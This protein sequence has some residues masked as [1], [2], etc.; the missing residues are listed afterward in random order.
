[1]VHSQSG[2]AHMVEIR[3]IEFACLSICFLLII[4]HDYILLVHFKNVT[5]LQKLAGF[6]SV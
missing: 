2:N 3:V 1:M 6:P 4:H 5:N